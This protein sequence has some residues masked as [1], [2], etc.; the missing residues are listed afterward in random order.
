MS[1]INSSQFQQGHL[2]RWGLFTVIIFLKS[3]ARKRIH[4][5]DQPRGATWGERSN[6]TH[7][8]FPLKKKKKNFS[9]CGTPW[10]VQ[11]GDPLS[12]GTCGNYIVGLHRD[13]PGLSRWLR[14]LLSLNC[15]FSKSKFKTKISRGST[16][17]TQLGVGSHAHRTRGG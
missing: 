4:V 10:L 8:I 16:R 2:V 13:H 3:R 9:T 5:L 11:I 17:N 14:T 6:Q 1:F 12:L 15:P 7:S